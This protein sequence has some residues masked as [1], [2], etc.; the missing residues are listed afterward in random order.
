M[1]RYW[2]KL[3]NMNEKAF[4]KKIFLMIKNDANIN[5]TYNSANW[6]TQIKSILETHG[7]ADIWLNQSLQ[8]P[9]L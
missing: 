3:I 7:Y 1:I 5:V 4:P 9:F 6:A 8:F 2:L